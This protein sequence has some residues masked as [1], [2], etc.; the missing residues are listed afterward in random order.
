M[1]RPRRTLLQ[2]VLAGST[3]R[4]LDIPV[5]LCISL[6]ALLAGLCCA[7]LAHHILSVLVPAPR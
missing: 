2:V 6:L 7:V 4:A 1:H 5:L 3:P